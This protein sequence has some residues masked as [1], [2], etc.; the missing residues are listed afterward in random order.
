MCQ[1]SCKV[2]T[3]HS[4]SKLLSTYTVSLLFN[5][6]NPQEIEYL[7]EEVARVV[8]IEGVE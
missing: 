5:G 3:Y 1:P 4:F 7:V 8:L 6:E 2:S